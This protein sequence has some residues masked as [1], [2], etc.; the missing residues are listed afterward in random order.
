M[1]DAKGG[2]G[3]REI[4]RRC[5]ERKPDAR[6]P[7]AAVNSGLFV[8]YMSSSQMYPAFGEDD[9]AN[10]ESAQEPENER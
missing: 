10:E 6:N 5:V 4:L 9:G 2:V 8:T 1:L 3:E 7:S